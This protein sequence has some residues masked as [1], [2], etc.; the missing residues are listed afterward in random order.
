MGTRLLGGLG[1]GRRVAGDRRKVPGDRRKV[2][3]GDGRRVERGGRWL[4]GD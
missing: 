1:S 3:G 4:E 2:E